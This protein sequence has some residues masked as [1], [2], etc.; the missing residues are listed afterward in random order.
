MG[1][2]GDMQLR[3]VEIGTLIKEGIAIIFACAQVA[4]AGADPVAAVDRP[5][6][7]ALQ[8]FREASERGIPAA[9][10]GGRDFGGDGKTLPGVCHA[11]VALRHAALQLPVEIRIVEDQFHLPSS[12]GR[13]AQFHG[14]RMKRTRY[15]LRQVQTLNRHTFS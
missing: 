12:I 4:L 1:G 10:V 2:V 3:I 15:L 11:E 7:D 9:R 5:L 8:G 14:E 13:S 6:S